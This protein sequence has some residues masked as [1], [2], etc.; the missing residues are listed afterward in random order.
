[1][2]GYRYVAVDYE[3][4]R[5]SFRPCYAWTNHWQKYSL[6]GELLNIESY[7]SA[8]AKH[9]SCSLGLAP[10]L[11]SEVAVCLCIHGTLLVPRLLFARAA[12]AGTDRRNS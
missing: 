7:Q 8:Y 3:D 5:A 9:R 2:I 6:L 10:I 4:W 12:A 11:A 1:M